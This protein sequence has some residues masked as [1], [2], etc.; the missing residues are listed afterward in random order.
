MRACRPLVDAHTADAAA[1]ML[2]VL[3]AGIEPLWWSL[4][5][6]ERDRLVVLNMGTKSARE[7]AQIAR[8]L[9]WLM[10]V[11]GEGER[12]VFAEGAR[13]EAEAMQVLATFLAD[14]RIGVTFGDHPLA[15]LRDVLGEPTDALLRDLTSPHPP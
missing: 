4:S 14:L 3:R 9:A 2:A 13:D 1:R 10:G 7:G 12:L 8:Y 15:F 11:E 5:T 6:A